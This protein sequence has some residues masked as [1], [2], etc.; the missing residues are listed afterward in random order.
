MSMLSAP[1]GTETTI[2]IQ[3]EPNPRLVVACI[4]VFFAVL[5]AITL[6]GLPQYTDNEW[7][8]SAYVLDVLQNGRWF[9]PT[10][11]NGEVISKPPMLVWLATLGAALTG[12][13]DRFAL[14]WPT[15]AAAAVTA[16]L[17]FVY[18]RK[19]FGWRA[20]LFAAATYGVSYIGLSQMSTARYDGLLSLFVMAAALAGFSAWH[21]GKGWTWFWLFV[22][23]GTLVKGPIA[24]GLSAFGLAA[25]LWERCSHRAELPGFRGSHWGGIILFLVIA[26]GWFALAYAEMGQ[27]LIDK[28]LGRE[29]LGHAV[30][31]ERGVLSGVTE[32]TKAFLAIYAPWSVVA[33]VGFWRIIR[34]PATDGRHRRLERF[35][36]L[37]FALG[38]LMFSL[39]AH[40][41]SR[42][43]YP[44]VPAA[45]LVIGL[46][47]ARW[48][49]G[50]PYRAVLASCGAAAAIF[51]GGCY[52]YTHSL[53]AHSTR[54][55]ETLAM[56]K[57]AQRVNSVADDELT[58]VS[59]PLSLKVWLND[60]E[61]DLTP[62]EAAARLAGA[63]PMYVVT[64]DAAR[65]RAAV[66][67]KTPVHEVFSWS[68]K[69]SRVAILS[70]RRS[71]PSRLFKT[72][73]K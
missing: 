71:L 57:L 46:Q 49:S 41:R 22:A 21:S 27:P 66:D 56:R 63:A 3:P 34:C 13:V 10:D 69:R 24:L 7:R 33:V 6:T 26:G 25:Y 23:L 17:L 31:D 8:L 29:L 18:G 64:K 19:Y 72:A 67:G 38:L 15:A 36:L 2:A 48:T 45:A 30:R 53:M 12:R 68:G 40:Q 9:C 65:I 42:L 59:S 37:W 47:M 20:G 28:M 11:A 70:N 73:R 51:L 5:F 52:A 35:L 43:I 4:L 16:L 54:V 62:A 44:L 1:E 14:Y 55:Q 58:Y 50:V 32:P 61:P 60:R 39:A